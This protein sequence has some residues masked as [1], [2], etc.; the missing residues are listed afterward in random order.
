MNIRK[1]TINDYEQVYSLWLSTPN[2]GLN[3]L[4]D[5]KDGIAKYLARNPNTCFVAER[6]GNIIGVIL[7]GHDG[8]R[9]FIY[10]AAVAQSEQ[11]QGIGATLVSEAMSALEREGINKT[12]LLVMAK[13]ESGN[14]F[15]EKQGFSPRSDLVYRNKVIKESVIIDT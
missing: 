10:H 14:V 2:M 3:N 7:S 5:S 9:G 12:A 11:R 15:W 13:N 4:D 1:M 6:N 8:R